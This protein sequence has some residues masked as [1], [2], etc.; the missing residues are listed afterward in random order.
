MV[1]YCF[2]IKTFS[3]VRAQLLEMAIKK[4][5]CN[6]G[7]RVWSLTCDGAK[8]NIGPLKELGHNLHLE[9]KDLASNFLHSNL[10][11]LFTNILIYV[12]CLVS[13]GKL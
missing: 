13:S 2:F 8:K 7:I 6:F 1:Y 4:T 10:A 3:A 12:N 9:S 5:V 11:T